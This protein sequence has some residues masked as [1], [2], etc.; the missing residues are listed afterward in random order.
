MSRLTRLLL[1]ANMMLVSDSYCAC[2]VTITHQDFN[3][4]MIFG[5]VCIINI[6]LDNETTEETGVDECTQHHW[7]NNDIRIERALHNTGRGVIHDGRVG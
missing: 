7:S 6:G 1:P 2:Q 5:E 4:S 3:R